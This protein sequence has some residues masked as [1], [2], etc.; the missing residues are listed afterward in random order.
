MKDDTR[1]RSDGAM[2]SD[3]EGLDGNV[4]LERSQGLDLDL[5]GDSRFV[6]RGIRHD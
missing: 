5:E 2:T 1:E 6:E 4:G 3:E